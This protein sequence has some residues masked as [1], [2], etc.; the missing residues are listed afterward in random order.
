MNFAGGDA[1]LKNP[2]V[3]TKFLKVDLVAPARFLKTGRSARNSEN[4]ILV[5]AVWFCGKGE[6]SISVTAVQF[7]GK[8]ENSI[9]VTAMR[10]C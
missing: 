8:G 9:S 5:T 3:R 10:F 7:C 1:F 6:N 4:S 2:S